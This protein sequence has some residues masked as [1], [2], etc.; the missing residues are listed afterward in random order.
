MPLA[1]PR[2]LGSSAAQPKYLRLPTR[3]FARCQPRYLEP[4]TQVSQ[5]AE[6]RY[7]GTSASSAHSKRCLGSTRRC[8]FLLVLTFCNCLE[9]FCAWQGTTEEVRGGQGRPQR[10]ESASV[11]VCLALVL[12]F[13]AFV[14]VFGAQG[15]QDPRAF[16]SLLGASPFPHSKI[17][18]L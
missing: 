11:L 4:G 5:P 10:A 14:M 12:A 15:S 6:P 3:I 16:P 7:I 18:A 9:I 8:R 2:Y 13:L 17:N 1:Q